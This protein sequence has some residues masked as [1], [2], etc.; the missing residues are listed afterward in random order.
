[1]TNPIFS[2]EREKQKMIDE[3]KRIGY[4]RKTILSYCFWIDKFFKYCNKGPRRVTKKEVMSYLN[5]LSSK[6]FSGSTMNI[7]L[8]AI[9]FLFEEIMHRNIYLRVKYSR[10]AKIIPTVLSK[11]EIRKLFESV[12][13]EKHKLMIELMYSAGLRVSELLNLRVKDF[14]IDAGF[15]WVRHG[16][17]NKDRFFIVAEGLKKRI[18]EFVGCK[19]DNGDCFLFAGNNGRMS[20][21]TVQ[22]IVKSAA[23]KAAIK[24]NVHP[25]T[26]RHSF[27]THLVEQGNEI[28]DVKELLG[29]GSLQTTMMYVHAANPIMFNVKSPFDCL[30]V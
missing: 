14:E 24:K 15:G 20:A 5:Y 1:M 12:E 11:E 27:A 28:T 16:K 18:K 8:S 6:G 22:E 10:R 17:G 13:N 30:Y 21:R 19:K 4:S 26:L 3:M 2:I 9:K 23:K 7:C 25:H 29:H